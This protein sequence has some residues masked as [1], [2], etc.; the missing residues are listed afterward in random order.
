M[1][2]AISERGT[3]KALGSQNMQ[4]TSF[5]ARD[6]RDGRSR[7]RAS[8]MSASDKLGWYRVYFRPYRKVGVFYFLYLFMEVE[9]K[10]HINPMA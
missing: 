1:F 3:V 9:S 10:W 2:C 5:V 4:A 6:D 8:K 7:Y